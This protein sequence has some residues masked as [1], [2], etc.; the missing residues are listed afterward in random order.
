MELHGIIGTRHL[1]DHTFVVRFERKGLIFKPGQHLLASPDQQNTFRE[2]SIY[3]GENDPWLEI[4]VREV[5]EGHVSKSLK[6]LNQG[7]Q[8]LIDGPM[9]FFQVD[10]VTISGKK[11]CFIASG[12]GIAPFHSMVKSYP[13]LDYLLIHGIRYQNEQYDKDTYQPGRYISCISKDKSGNY[14]GRVTGYLESNFPGTDMHYYLCGN[15][16]MIRD[17]FELLT[18]K[19]IERNYIHTEVYF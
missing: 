11:I 16:N 4:L 12:T 6:H 17:V 15:F 18:E 1:T 9:G 7:D 8:I 10:P 2:Y 5:E 13:S 3:S 14:F 19:E